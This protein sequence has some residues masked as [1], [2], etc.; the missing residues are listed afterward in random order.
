MLVA[1]SWKGLL[2][3]KYI[4]RMNSPKDATKVFS[5]LLIE[6]QPEWESVTVEQLN[7]SD[8]APRLHLN[9]LE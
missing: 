3:H 4:H 9:P 7:N 2:D 5:K 6:N 8:A 1:L